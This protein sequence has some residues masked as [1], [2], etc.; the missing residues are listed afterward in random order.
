MTILLFLTMMVGPLVKAEACALVEV[1]GNQT[2]EAQ[3]FVPEAS[4]STVR[5]ANWQ[6]TLRFSENQEVVEAN[7]QRRPGAANDTQAVISCD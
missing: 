2:I 1:R 5:T 7:V 6:G 3:D 4:E